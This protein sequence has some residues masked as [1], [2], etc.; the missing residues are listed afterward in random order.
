MSAYTI[1]KFAHVLLAIVAVG[2]N[3]SYGVWIARAARDHLRVIR[4]ADALHCFYDEL[5]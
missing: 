5:R 4:R 3:A 1:L 2:F